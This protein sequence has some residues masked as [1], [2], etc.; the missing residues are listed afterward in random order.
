MDFV[1]FLEFLESE[2]SKIKFIF[3]IFWCFFSVVNQPN[4]HVENSIGFIIMSNTIQQCQYSK[5]TKSWILLLARVFMILCAI[6]CV[7]LDL[8]T[9]LKDKPIKFTCNYF[10]SYYVFTRNSN[11]LQ[12]YFYHCLPQQGHGKSL[13]LMQGMF[14]ANGGCGYVKKPQILMQKHQCGNEFDPT[15]ILT[16]KKTLKVS[17]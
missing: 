6:K 4:L 15:W 7:A 17:I 9:I 8:E 14:R 16:V 1:W 12:L 2:S 13:W 11:L 10:K 3:G 5:W